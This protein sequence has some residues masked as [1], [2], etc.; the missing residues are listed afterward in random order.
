MKKFEQMN[1]TELVALTEEE[2]ADIIKLK[3]A[4]NGVKILVRPIAPKLKETPEQDIIVYTVAG[5]SFLEKEPA[6]EICE[7]L[8]KHS[9]KM[10]SVDYN[11]K[12]GSDK[13]YIKPMSYN[14][15]EN[16]SVEKVYSENKYKEIQDTLDSNNVLEVAYK[17]L[18]DEYNSEEE[19][20]KDI[21][22]N[23]YEEIQKAKDR[24]SHFVELKDRIVDYIKLANGDR[25][26]AWNF[27]D[28]AYQVEVSVKNMIMESEEYKNA[29]EA[30]I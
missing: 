16:V 2:I 27:F 3:K 20:A 24:I 4:E 1:D 28:K 25:D 18:L 5:K 12:L 6:E 9:H 17:K 8:N 29:L 14:N 15:L 30:Y 19:K 23:V 21:V 26:I 11:W 13:K 22:N 7:V 10:V